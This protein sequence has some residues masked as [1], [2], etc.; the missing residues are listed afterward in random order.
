DGIIHEINVSACKILGIDAE[1][2][3]D[4]GQILEDFFTEGI[5][6]GKTVDLKFQA[7]RRT[8]RCIGEIDRVDFGQN[9]SFYSIV[10]KEDKTLNKMANKITGNTASYTFDQIVTSDEA[11]MA[12]MAYAKKTADIDCCV[13]I[14][15]ASGTGKELFAQSIHNSS[16]RNKGPF[17]AINCAALPADLVESELFGY[18]TGAFT[19]AKH[20]GQPGKI[21]LAEGGTLFLDEVGEL[22][23]NIQSKLLRFLD[24]RRVT[25]LGGK[26]EKEI[27]VRMITATNRNLEE[28]VRAKNFRLDLFYRINMIT[29]KLPELNERTGDIA[30]LAHYFLQK[31]NR[32]NDRFIHSIHP[33]VVAL[34]ENFEWEGNVRQLQN[35]VTRA[36]YLCEG[37]QITK[38]D[39]PENMQCRATSNIKPAQPKQEVAL[40]PKEDTLKAFERELIIETIEACKGNMTQVAKTLNMAKSTLYRKIKAHKIE[41]KRTVFEFKT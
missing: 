22:P 19:G 35:I 24:N 15:G 30:L 16:K 38:K 3:T 11:T 6:K 40:P 12:L 39:L 23:L 26:D 31:L 13:L 17:I 18:E 32:E 9:T 34:F 10:F 21:E 25:R 27:D 37:Q 1:S 14:L 4:I 2:V 7:A 41:I 36:Y 33:E 8:C 28:E 20:G 5:K 29:L